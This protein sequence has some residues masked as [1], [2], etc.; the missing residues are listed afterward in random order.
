M[1]T[2]I[3]ILKA[4]CNK[5]KYFKRPKKIDFSGG[6]FKKGRQSPHTTRVNISA[7]NPPKIEIFL[8]KYTF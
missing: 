2:C 4:T 1:S 5:T 8:S 7:S 3:I 6:H